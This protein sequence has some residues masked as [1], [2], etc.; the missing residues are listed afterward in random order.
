MPF[1]D[2]P[3]V[4]EITAALAEPDPAVNPDIS[5]NPWPVNVVTLADLGSDD[6]QDDIGG[7]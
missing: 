3:T 7:D 6:D 4:D 2:V 1:S 5:T